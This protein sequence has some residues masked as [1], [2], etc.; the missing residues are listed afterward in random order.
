[1]SPILRDNRVWRPHLSPL[2]WGFHGLA[3]LAFIPAANYL[4]IGPRYLADRQ[5]MVVGTAIVLA[6][7]IPI[8]A[9]LTMAVSYAIRQYSGVGQTLKRILLMLLLSSLITTVT[10]IASVGIISSIPLLGVTFSAA[11]MQILIITGLIFS[12]LFSLSHGYFYALFKWQQEQVQTEQLKK[13]TLQSQFDALKSQVNPHFLFNSLTSLSALISDEPKQ[14]ERFV[15]ELAKV[16]RYLL[17]TGS[18]ELTT[19]EAE[20]TFLS[21]YLYLLK[22]RYGNGISVNIDIKTADFT[23]YLPSLTLQTLVE[24]AVTHNMTLGHKPLQ[25]QICTTDEPASAP[26]LMVRNPI[27]KRTIRAV[28]LRR[29]ARSTVADQS[30]LMNLAAKYRLLSKQEIVVQNDGDYF[31]VWLPLLSNPQPAAIS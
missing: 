3:V 1:M 23:A 14:A 7:Y 9:L 10:A 18:T 24:N 11:N 5:V 17:S 12:L 8:N 25:I 20:L 27:Q 13:A 19:L 29:T 16:Y 6:L 22:T 4:L 21:S 31:T 15:D 30:G 28:P 2:E 26:Q